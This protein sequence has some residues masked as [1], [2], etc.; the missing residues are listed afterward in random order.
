MQHKVWG[1][2]ITCSLW[3]GKI[4]RGDVPRPLSLLPD[5]VPGSGQFDIL[6]KD[7]HYMAPSDQCILQ[8]GNGVDQQKGLPC[9]TSPQGDCSR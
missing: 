1:W 5:H 4:D 8:Q 3:I 6:S 2:Q 9:D 7:S